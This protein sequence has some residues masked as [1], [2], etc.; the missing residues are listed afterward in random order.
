[1]ASNTDVGPSPSQEDE[2]QELVLHRGSTGL[3]FNIRG[4]QDSPY[5]PEDSGVF[6][7]KIRS[8]GGA[9]KDGRL[10]EGDKILA[11]NGVRLEGM[12]HVEAVNHFLDAGE[13]VRL[14]IVAGAERKIVS[15][16]AAAAAA[17]Q[18]E[19]SLLGGALLATSALTAVVGLGLAAAFI[20]RHY[21]PK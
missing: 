15:A 19:Y 16:R 17:Q 2:E 11:I 13:E 4:G 10:K 8:N 14:V 7:V 21:R 20:Y 12:T 6:V 18:A 5:L 1:M 3:G 9:A